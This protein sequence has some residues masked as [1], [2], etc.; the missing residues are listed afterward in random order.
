MGDI[1]EIIG[2]SASTIFDDSRP[3]LVAES[4]LFCRGCNRELMEIPESM[5]LDSR[6]LLR[7]YDHMLTEHG[8]T[9]TNILTAFESNFIVIRHLVREV[10]K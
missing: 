8:F 9:M 2:Y 3:E 7:V 6:L 5:P 4:V 1:G 10:I